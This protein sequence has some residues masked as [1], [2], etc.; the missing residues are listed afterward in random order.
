MSIRVAVQ[1]NHISGIKIA[2]DS[3]FAILIEGQKR[4]H[5]L[6]HYTP[7]QL[8]LKDG[9]LVAPLQA[10][11][12][13][14]N[15]NDHYRL[16]QEVRCELK[17]MDA[18][19]LRQDPPFDMAYVSSTYLLEKIHPETLVVN[20]P[21]HVRN[22]PEKIFVTEFQDLMPPTLISRDRL[23]IESFRRDLGDIVMKPLYGNGGEAVFKVSQ[24]DLNFG[25]LFD[26]FSS[27][28]QEQWVIQQFIPEVAAGDK[29]IIL[30]D[31]NFAGAINRI[32]SEGDLRSNM[33]Q[34]GAATET[35]LS[36]RE[37]EICERLFKPLRDRG[38]IFVGI[39][40]INDKMTEINV[41]SPTGIRAVTNVG[42]PDIAAM[43]W[44]VV[45][46]KIHN[47]NK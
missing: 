15:Q 1:M 26:L 28:Y 38:L 46:D 22:S 8:T 27:T 39:D 44:D 14:D 17:E 42:G 9:K 43:Y 21:T 24:N 45:E 40:V 6:F 12:V 13:H 35:E 23:E 32:P 5:E 19:F 11:E 16:G 34:G 36:D 37:L 10:L 41:T 20:D 25:S 33:V 30:I 47:N 18:V 31:G 7:D 2:G 3:T 4:G 29:R